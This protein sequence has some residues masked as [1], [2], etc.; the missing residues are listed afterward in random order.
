[1]TVAQAERHCYDRARLAAHPR[2]MVKVGV[3]SGGGTRFGLG[4]EVSSDYL[5]G[6]DPSAI[7]DACVMQKSGHP[8]S[9]PL[10]SRPDWGRP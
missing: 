6:R 8:P 7:Y 3:G 9:R 5:Q 2:G 10:Y 4:L 1:M